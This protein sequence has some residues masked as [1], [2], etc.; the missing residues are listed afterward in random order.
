MKK[1][2]YTDWVTKNK[3]HKTLTEGMS[4]EEW[5]GAKEKDRL[6]QHPEK[7]TINKIK[8]M[9][10]KEKEEM[11]DDPGD[12]RIDHDY[13]ANESEVSEVDF[14]DDEG[15]HAKMQLQK[16]TEYSAK[17]AV[18][19]DDIKQLP[20]W[21][22]A[23]ITKASDYMS[24]VYHYLDYETSGDQEDLTTET[25]PDWT[26]PPM[27]MGGEEK[28]DE[29]QEEYDR[30]WYSESLKEAAS[31][32]GYL[33]ENTLPISLQQLENEINKISGEKSRVSETSSGIYTVKFSYVKE[34]FEGE[35]W[36]EILKHI[37]EHPNDYDIQNQ[38]NYY[39]YGRELEEQFVPYI[40]FK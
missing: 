10:D 26:P 21:I 34:E 17:L 1:F 39:E 15:S 13:Y 28:E 12:I 22:Q 38:R 20:S 30:G 40:T 3:H 36:K 32:L 24:S 29:E 11:H 9:M 37:D 5:D 4:P 6:N 2:N 16:A 23:K 8:K 7:D 33:E 18:M 31:Q 25:R 19:M 14:I 35:K 27:G